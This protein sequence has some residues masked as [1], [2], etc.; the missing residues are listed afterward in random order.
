MTEAISHQQGLVDLFSTL[1]LFFGIAGFAVPFLQKL[2]ISPVLGYLF[3]G[4]IIGPLGL[5]QFSV[6]LSWLTHF[7]ISEHETVR[8]LGEL[9]IIALLFMI[10]LELSFE[11]L[12]KIKH[13]VIGLGG[14]QIII[15][16][17][18]IA[19]IASFFDNSHAT[20]LLLGASIAL[21]STAIVMHLLTAAKLTQKPI[22]TLCFS[23]LLM[24]D[25][26]VVPILIMASV[27]TG[28]AEQSIFL[29]ILSSLGIAA[30]VIAAI[31][32]IGKTLLRPLMNHLSFNRNP[33]WLIAFVL[34]IIVAFAS[35]TH[36]TGLS[37]ALGAFLAGLLIAETE[38]KPE[39]ETIITPLK[40]LL[41]GIFFL[42][43][44]MM[45]DVMAVLDNPLWIAASI[46]GI[47]AI[48]AGIIYPL[49]RIFK[50]SKRQSIQLSL[51]L[52]Q[53]GEFAF[54]ILSVMHASSLLPTNNY[55]F[56]L[57]VTALAMCLSPLQ[58]KL[59]SILNER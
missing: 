28:D 15:T 12:Y 44:G 6:D 37:A 47:A 36:A 27:F 18:A 45:I 25:L 33:E 14:L 51:I 58:F 34:F 40:S 53:P 1:L 48:K 52:A 57:L 55:Q 59:A 32:A 10:G 9:G 26:A 21:S 29:A 56:F 54:L 8:I 30:L 16:T 49:A 17:I 4:I 24:Q 39:I 13:Y 23:I 41:L 7:T 2:R 50:V 3:C 5:G 46:I 42:S 35:I 22:G 11:K 38:F 31:Y 20:I 19:L 43:I